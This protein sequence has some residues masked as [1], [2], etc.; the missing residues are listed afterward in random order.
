MSPSTTTR[1]P[2]MPSTTSTAYQGPSTGATGLPL[3]AWQ[4]SRSQRLEHDVV[5]DVRAGEGPR[6]QREE[7]DDGLWPLF[8]K[9]PGDAENQRRRMAQLRSRSPSVFR[10]D[11]NDQI[12]ANDAARMDELEQQLQEAQ[13]A[14]QDLADAQ[15]DLKRQLEEFKYAKHQARESLERDLAE[16][17]QTT[18]ERCT[19]ALARLIECL[20]HQ[21]LDKATVDN[22]KRKGTWKAT[23]RAASGKFFFI[24]RHLLDEHVDGIAEPRMAPTM[25][26]PES[27]TKIGNQM[28]RMLKG[29][30]SKEKW[31]HEHDQLLDHR[32][33]NKLSFGGV[34]YGHAV[35]EKAF[36]GTASS[37]NELLTIEI[38][39]TTKADSLGL[40]I[41]SS[42]LKINGI[43]AG[44]VHDWN[45][46]NNNPASVVKIGDRI[47]QVNG[48]RC[49][50]IKELVDIVK[51]NMQLRL[52]I[53]QA[54]GETT[55]YGT[56]SSGNELMQRRLN[57]PVVN[58]PPPVRPATSKLPLPKFWSE[59]ARLH[60]V[61]HNMVECST[62]E[63]AGLIAIIE[64]SFL[65][66]ATVDR[67]ELD[68]LPDHL[69]VIGAQRSENPALWD[70]AHECYDEDAQRD[71]AQG[72]T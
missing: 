37:S 2:S 26:N 43:T 6:R 64:Q 15:R 59:E 42:S 60:G 50:Q 66:I 32:I 16:A 54:A 69:E 72:A 61:A 22:P 49:Q 5:D 21:E 71:L 55:F 65:S 51:L 31:T 47:V 7:Q 30:K 68:P 14:R 46:N 20:S 67:T 3:A 13:S 62:G 41:D 52:T 56:A 58:V 63:L 19:T 27:K 25:S 39:K 70:V 4:R 9:E 34:P 35:D 33:R 36:C 10:W 53:E 45:N 38:G 24:L 29:Q 17:R 11:M 12:M 23:L 28:R 48:V 8:R 44:L 1:R 18:A 40:N 57:P